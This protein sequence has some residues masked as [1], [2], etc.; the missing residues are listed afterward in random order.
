[1]LQVESKSLST[2]C[3]ANLQ[4]VGFKTA[5]VLATNKSML[6]SGKVTEQ[7]YE[8]S[9]SGTV[10]LIIN[11]GGLSNK[12]APAEVKK[13]FSNEI[14]PALANSFS[15]VSEKYTGKIELHFREGLLAN[16]NL[17]H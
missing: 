7:S 5:G 6:F 2:S 16:F 11:Q 13:L 15:E 12:S 14:L 10:K 9:F 1:M 3:W 4:Y 17:P 8:S